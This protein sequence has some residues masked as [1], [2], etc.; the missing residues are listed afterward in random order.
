MSGWPYNTQRWQRLRKLKLQLHPLCEVC[1]RVGR[2]EPAF[3]VDHR[4]PIN[5][6]GDPYPALDALASLCERCHN[7]KTRS[8]QLGETDW[9]TKGCDV[10]GYPLDPR[11]PWYRTQ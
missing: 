6:G 8:E 9:F 11:H 2:I 7:S 1:L 5:A 3:A 4:K 10:N